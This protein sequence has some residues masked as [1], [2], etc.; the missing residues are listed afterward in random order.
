MLE[1][2][3]GLPIETEHKRPTA[4]NRGRGRGR[5][6]GRNDENYKGTPF[7]RDAVHKMNPYRS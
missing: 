7:F 6:D 5:V 1:R 4:N 2:V 3:G